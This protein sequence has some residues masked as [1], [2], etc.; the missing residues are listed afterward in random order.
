M[1]FRELQV[2]EIREVLRPWLRGESIPS[3]ERLPVTT[4]TGDRTRLDRS[5]SMVHGV[6]GS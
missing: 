2:Q 4:S 1:A 5:P 6:L 3:I